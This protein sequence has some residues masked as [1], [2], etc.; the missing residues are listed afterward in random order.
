[1]RLQG[2]AAPGPSSALD[3]VN[4]PTEIVPVHPN[5]EVDRID[6][7]STTLSTRGGEPSINSQGSQFSSTMTGFKIASSLIPIFDGENL[8]VLTFIE[9]C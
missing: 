7:L 1:M 5:N 2:R 3:N 9:Y 8:P 4:L 6:D